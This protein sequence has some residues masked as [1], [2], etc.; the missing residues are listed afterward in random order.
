MKKRLFLCALLALITAVNLFAASDKKE[1]VYTSTTT[2]ITFRVP[3]NVK[4]IQDNI[5]AVILQTPDKEYTITAEAF[6][7]SKTTQEDI[8]KH[9][10]IMAEAAGIDLEQSESI[11]N[12]SEIITLMGE[13]IDFD[14]GGAAAVGVAIVNETTLGYYIT[15][16][17]SAKYVDYA[18]SSLRTISFDPDAVE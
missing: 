7:I 6:D 4:E 1:L 10:T 2:G 5:E 15:V 11:E 9:I 16:V 3:A 18:V 14:N 8:A 17:A 13:A 12:K